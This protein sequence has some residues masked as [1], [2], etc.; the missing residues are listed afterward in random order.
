MFWLLSKPYYDAGNRDWITVNGVTTDYTY[1]SLD[2]LI[3][4][5]SITYGYDDRGNL[6]QI[7]NGSNITN[8]TYDAADRLTNVTAPGVTATYGYDADGRRV[9]QT[10]NGQVTN[11]LW[12]EASPYGDVV[13]EYNGSGSPLASYVLGGTQLISQTRGSS[14]N[15]YLQDGQGSTRALTNSTGTVTD[16][17]SYTAFGELFDQTGSTTNS[18]LYTGQQF[19]SLTGLYSLRARYYN[20]ALGRFLSQDTYPFDLGNPVELNRYVYTADNPINAMDPT[21]LSAFIE[22]SVANEESEE[23]GAALEPVGK[24]FA[25]EADEA[26]TKLFNELDDDFWNALSRN[27]GDL[28]EETVNTLTQQEFSTINIPQP[29]GFATQEI[30]V[31]ALQARTAVENGANL[32]KFG[33]LENSNLYNS[34]YWSLDNP[35]LN[36]SYINDYGIPAG[37]TQGTQFLAVGKIVDGAN[38]ITRTAPGVGSNLGGAIEVVVE[39]FGVQI[40]DIIFLTL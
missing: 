14:T 15:Y 31:E 7:T 19:D 3:S 27:A 26:V 1:N 6:S 38:F 17:Y 2:Q 30:S 25:S 23:E 35:V 21:G 11:S 34:Q 29:P 24:K 9:T 39:E 28:G 5:G 4:A 13:Y 20:P 40:F 36:P 10:F 16:T 12:D 33:T 8:Y 37:N 22:Y 32:Y 18:Y